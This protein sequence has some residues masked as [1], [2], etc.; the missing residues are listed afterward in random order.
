M[1]MTNDEIKRAARNLAATIFTNKPANF[2]TVDLEAQIAALDAWIDANIAVYFG[3]FV[4]DF[5]AN[6]TPEDKVAAFLATV[7]VRN[8]LA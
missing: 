5:A 2:T 1:A 3:A 8:G 7:A 4:G 6:A